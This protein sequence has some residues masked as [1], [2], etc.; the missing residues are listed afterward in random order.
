M[1]E[2]LAMKFEGPAFDRHEI[3]ANILANSLLALD[4]LARRCAEVAYGK[5][6]DIQ[7]KV[8]GSPREGSFITDLL[9]EHSGLIQTGGGAVTIFMGLVKFAKWAYG[10]AVKVVE[11][12]TGN[13]ILVRNEIGE[14]QLIKAAIL[15]LYN[16]KR[17]SIEIARLT[18]ALSKEGAERIEFSSPDTASETIS[19]KEAKFFQSGEGEILTDSEAPLI[20]QVIGPMLDGSPEGWTFSEGEDGHNFTARVEDQH[21]LDSVK[22]NQIQLQNGMSLLALVRIVQRRVQRTITERTVIEVLE[23]Y[24]PQ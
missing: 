6:S 15:H 18:Q 2:L 1:S 5:E 10:K 24:P 9:V 8:K 4:A 23:V 22:N 21:F 16:L 14:E 11:V 3:P 17:T 12:R 20:L 7:I 13:E 19:R